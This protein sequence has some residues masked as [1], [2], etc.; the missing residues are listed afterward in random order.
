MNGACPRYTSP[1]PPATIG[2]RISYGPRREPAD[3]SISE[4]G[5]APGP[6]FISPNDSFQAR[7]GRPDLTPARIPFN[8]PGIDLSGAD[9]ARIEVPGAGEVV[10]L[11]AG[12]G[13]GTIMAL[14][15]GGT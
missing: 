7:P 10:D 8:G 11:A 9:A 6:L 1:M 3:R 4:R 2:A 15:Y 13:V 14:G 12:V 5:T